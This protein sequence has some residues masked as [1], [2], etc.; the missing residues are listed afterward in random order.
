MTQAENLRAERE[1][2]TVAYTLFLEEYN[3]HKPICYGFVEGKDDPSYYQCHIDNYLP[4]G[5]KIRLFPTGRKE[6]VKQ[7][8]DLFDWRSFD[9]KRIVFFMDRD[10]SDIIRDPHIINDSNVYITDQ[11]SIEN[12]IICSDT[13]E[14]VLRQL[15]G[16][17]ETPQNQID[18]VIRLFEIAREK[19]DSIMLPVMANVI[20][21]K[22][23]GVLT[24]N[25]RNVK[26]NHIVS[27]QNGC[28]VILKTEEEI[29]RL[30]YKQSGLEL[31]L[32][33]K[34]DVNNICREIVTKGCIRSIIRGK[35]LATFFIEFCNSVCRDCTRIA[36]KKTHKGC[37]ISEV[38]IMRM[39]AP[40]CRISNSLRSFINDTILA[41]IAAA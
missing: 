14:A 27:V 31:A 11:Y 20:F 7:T 5:Y 8:Y 38:D 25:Y 3:K 41:Y 36:I 21:W 23:G 13:L 32:Y 28:L 1:S 4:A 6:C 12:D 22:K 29:I 9:K 26:I 33:N 39:I 16:F 37:T 17:A 24:A 15:L 2:R 40:R 34:E 19:F 30:I 35:Y 10:L 18:T